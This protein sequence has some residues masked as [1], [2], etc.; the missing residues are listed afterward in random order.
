MYLRVEFPEDSTARL[1]G[2]AEAYYQAA[3]D[4][5][6]EPQ[7]AAMAMPAPRLAINT[8]AVSTKRLRKPPADDASSLAPSPAH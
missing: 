6:D 4:D 2:I 1:A 7:A 8:N 5:D 3:P